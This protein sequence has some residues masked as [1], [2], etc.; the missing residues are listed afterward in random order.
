[1]CYPLWRIFDTYGNPERQISDNGPPFGSA[2]MSQFAKDRGISLQKAAPYHPSSNVVENSMRT[3]GKAMK[4]GHQ[5]NTPEKISLSK[6]LTSYRN[7]PHPSSGISPKSMLFRDGIQSEFPQKSV[8]DEAVARH[9][10]GM[11]KLRRDNRIMLMMENT[12]SDLV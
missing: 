1:M 2:K 12:E 3:L 7:N 9:E 8:Y 11:E 4:I 6:C 10:K 5:Q